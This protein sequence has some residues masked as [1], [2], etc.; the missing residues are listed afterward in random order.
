MQRAR[1]SSRSCRH[2]LAE[3]RRSL[4]AIGGV[5]RRGPEVRAAR[6]GRGDR[7]LGA[8]CGRAAP[9][10]TAMR[11][12]RKTDSNTECVTNTTVTP[13]R[14]HSSSRSP[15]SRCRVISSSA[16][17]GSSISSSRGSDDQ[18]ARDRHAHLHAARQFAR[19]GALE[20]LEADMVERLG[21]PRLALAPWHAAQPAAAA[22]RWRARSPTASGSAPG[23]RSRDRPRR[24][25]APGQSIVPAVGWISPAISRSRVDLPQPEGPS[26]LRNS[27]SSTSSET[28]ASACTPLAKTLETPRTPTSGIRPAAG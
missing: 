18:G 6:I 26:T 4:A 3:P 15:F 12:D 27:D 8:A 16:A 9:L 10:I 11:C 20:A 13:V 25:L 2:R 23:R 24:A 21:G 28:S 17:N 1:R 5:F 7:K 14:C 19:P 22:R